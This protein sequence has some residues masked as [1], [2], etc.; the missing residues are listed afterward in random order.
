MVETLD[1]RMMRYG[2]KEIHDKKYVLY[3]TASSALKLLRFMNVLGLE[4]RIVAVCDSEIS[5][6]GKNWNGFRIISPQKIQSYIS[7]STI[8]IVASV[9]VNEICSHLNEAGCSMQV[10]SGLAY[11]LSIHYD[12]MNSL[13]DYLDK[14][15]IDL[16]QKKY[17]I[18]KKICVDCDPD[19]KIASYN[20]LMN[21]C[22]YEPC[23]LLHSFPKT[24]NKSLIKSFAKAGNV[25]S[26]NHGICYSDISKSYF[27]EVMGVIGNKDIRIVTGVR[28]PIERIIAHRWQG[29]AR[30]YE[31]GEKCVSEFVD[32]TYS[33]FHKSEI[34]WLDTEIRDI[35]GIDVFEH[36]FDKTKGYSIMRKN[37]ISIFLYRLDFLNSL[38]KELGEFCGVEDFKLKSDNV[39]A[40]KY[41]ALAYS[42]YK[43]NIKIDKEFFAECLTSKEMTHFYTEEECSAYKEK[44]KD[45][46]C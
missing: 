19:E 25:H 38:E 39:G 33:S 37:N 6:E 27:D 44:W 28:E 23:I 11:W 26:T 16:Y 2:A 5:K 35:F 15:R 29:I 31:Y 21:I 18:Y 8:V 43:K 36:P 7:D 42:E 34:E 10:V 22:K 1:W 14:E 46:L 32:K 9:H 45:K 20:N 17:S 13:C 24:G 12:I 30:P 3:G 41:Y 4:D 40:D